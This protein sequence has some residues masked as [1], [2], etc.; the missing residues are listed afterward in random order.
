MNESLTTRYIHIKRYVYIAP[1]PFSLE[2]YTQ[3]P[4]HITKYKIALLADEVHSAFYL[5]KKVEEPP[6]INS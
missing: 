1:S 5:L 3:Y 6:L 4:S 2:T